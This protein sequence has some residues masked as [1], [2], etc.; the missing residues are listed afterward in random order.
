MHLRNLL[1]RLTIEHMDTTTAPETVEQFLAQELRQDVDHVIEL[2]DRPDEALDE[3]R[4][5]RRTELLSALMRDFGMAFLVAQTRVD[6]HLGTVAREAADAMVTTFLA[7]QTTADVM[8][9][10]KERKTL[11]NELLN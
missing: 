6:V 11:P 10:V 2:M 1:T 8:T 9:A 5:F 4:R 3:W 7:L